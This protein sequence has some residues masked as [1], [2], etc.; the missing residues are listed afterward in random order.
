MSNSDDINSF[1]I[2]PFTKDNYNH[3]KWKQ[4]ADKIYKLSGTNEEETI[5]YCTEFLQLTIELNQT[6]NH[7]QYFGD[8]SI[9]QAFYQEFFGRNA[10]NLIATTTFH[11]NK[12]LE[13]SNQTLINLI[14]FWIKAFFEDDIYLAEMAKIILDPQQTYY[15]SN[16]LEYLGSTSIVSI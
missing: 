1:Q 15:K 13:I 4:I 7:N 12:L 10:K 14:K 5:P 16:N 8:P 9:K 11:D 2:G 6:E 3:D